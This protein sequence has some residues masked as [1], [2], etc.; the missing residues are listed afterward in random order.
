[1]SNKIREFY[2]VESPSS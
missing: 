2:P 1:M